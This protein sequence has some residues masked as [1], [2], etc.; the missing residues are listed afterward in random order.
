[1]ETEEVVARLAQDCN[2]T[3]HLGLNPGSTAVCRQSVFLK[4]MN[5][6]GG[7]SDAQAQ[8]KSISRSPGNR[9]MVAGRG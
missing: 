6:D 7:G 5:D 2:H 4:H 1:L 8:A 3:S 9:S